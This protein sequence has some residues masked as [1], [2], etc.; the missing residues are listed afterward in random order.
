MG[1][2]ARQYVDFGFL[3]SGER[4][5]YLVDEVLQKFDE[6]YKIVMSI[7]KKECYFQEYFHDFQRFNF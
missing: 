1:V 7:V 2:I 5:S 3:M 4:T 6:D